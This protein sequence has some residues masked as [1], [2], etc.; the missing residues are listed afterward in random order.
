[1]ALEALKSG[2]AS[3]VKTRFSGLRWQ[4]SDVI[5]AALSQGEPIE[6][7]TRVVIGADGL[8]SAVGRLAGLE[9]VQTVLTCAQAEVYADVGHPDFVDV[10]WGRT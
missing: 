7:R 9:R 5:I 2:V 3:L 4:G 10:T 1:M 6:I 8:Q